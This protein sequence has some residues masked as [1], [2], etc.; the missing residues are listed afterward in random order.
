MEMASIYEMLAYRQLEL[1]VVR[2]AKTIAVIRGQRKAIA[3]E[4]Q[5]RQRDRVAYWQLLS[6][7]IGLSAMKL[8]GIFLWLIVGATVG[9]IAAHNFLSRGVFCDQ[10][11]CELLRFDGNEIEI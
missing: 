8:S 6:I 7:H 1:L 4:E 5:K 3:L 10:P 9:A 11:I 2:E